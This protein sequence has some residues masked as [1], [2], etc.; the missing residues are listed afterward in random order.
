MKQKKGLLIISA[1]GFYLISVGISYLGFSFLASKGKSRMIVSPLPLKLQRNQVDLGAPR[2]ESCPLRGDKFTR[3]EREIWEKRRPLGVMIE[4]HL[5][6]RPQ[7]GLSKADVIYETV[8]EGGITRFLAIF[9]CQA[10]A[11]D[12]LLGPVRSARTYY[13]DWISE[14][15]DWPLY[16]HVGGANLPGKVDALGQI[17]TYG[18]LKKGNDLNQFSLGFPVF[19]RDY[20]RLGRPVAT[21]HTMYSST[22]RLW[23]TAEKRG[24]TQ[25]DGEGH[26]WEEDFSKW[27][28]E[29]NLSQSGSVEEVT[30]PFWQNQDYFVTWRYD[31]QSRLYKRFQGATPHLDLNTNQS[32]EAGVV[33]VQLTRETGPVDALKHLLYQTTGEGKALIF[34]NGQVIEGNWTK[35]SRQDRTEF[36]ELEGKKIKFAPGQIWIEVVDSGT[37]IDY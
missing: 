18:W 13:L 19:W 36:F 6:S 1:V 10:A 3:G 21:E 15:G 37:K 5:D 29:E 8:A 34:Q 26:S 2:S 23:E 22:D 20:E 17:G 11:E 9:F 24:L 31:S 25:I 4:N 35:E 16:V 14:Y 27:T 33:V 30:V 28:F 12:V 32:L 7:S